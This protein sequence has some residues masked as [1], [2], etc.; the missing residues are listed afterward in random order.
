MTW[1]PC[2]ACDGAQ[3]ARD[4]C[5]ECHGNGGAFAMPPTPPKEIE[6]PWCQFCGLPIPEHTTRGQAASCRMTVRRG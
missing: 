2:P 1:V 5:K 3:P 4:T 6:S